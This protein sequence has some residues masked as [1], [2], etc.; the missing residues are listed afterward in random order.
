MREIC[1]DCVR[2][3]CLKIGDNSYMKKREAD[4]PVIIEGSIEDCPIRPA[5]PEREERYNDD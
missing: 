1:T 4:A 2:T 3:I 5:V